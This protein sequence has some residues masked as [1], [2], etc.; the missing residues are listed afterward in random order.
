MPK[1]KNVTGSSANNKPNAGKQYK[2]LTGKDVPAGK[3]AAHVTIE[4]QGKKQY[5][6]PATPAQNHPSNTDTYT[7]RHK[8]VPINE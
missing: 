3:V 4:G 6:V 8:P 2:K 1:V 5:L 7:V